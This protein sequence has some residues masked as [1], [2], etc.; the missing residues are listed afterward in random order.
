MEKNLMFEMRDWARGDLVK[1]TG[2]NYDGTPRKSYGV[3][4]ATF[5]NDKQTRIFPAISVYNMDTGT[6]EEHYVYDLEL[7]SESQA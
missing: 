5:Y 4:A 2:C 3:V 1:I 6:I 7:I